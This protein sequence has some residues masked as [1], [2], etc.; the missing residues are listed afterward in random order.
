M[1]QATFDDDELFSEAANEMRD[2]VEDHLDAAKAA[3]PTT[4]D[5]WAVEADNVLG[6]LNALKGSLD[7]GDA[8][9]ELRQAKKWYAIGERADAF[10]DAEDLEA[11][12]ETVESL[13]EQIETTR[14][15]VATLAGT[16]PQ[17]KGALDE[18]HADGADDDDA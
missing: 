5:F 6:A 2:D 9:D 1:S 13:F 16:V 18:A 7:L 10:E 12:L 15:Q 14:E 8:A 17:L 11:E 4:E 3:L